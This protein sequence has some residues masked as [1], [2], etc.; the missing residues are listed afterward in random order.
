MKLLLLALIGLVAL[1]AASP[2][3]TTAITVPKYKNNGIH[4]Y[5]C[6]SNTNVLS[7][8]SSGTCS[9]V[10]HCSTKCFADHQGAGCIGSSTVAIEASEKR[11]TETEVNAEAKKT[12][13]CSNDHTGVLVCQYGFCQT[14]RYCKKGTKCHDKCSCCRNMDV[15]ERDIGDVDTTK[16]SLQSEDIFISLPSITSSPIVPATTYGSC[17]QTQAGVQSCR[18]NNSM[19]VVCDIADYMW[20]VLWIA[21]PESDDDFHALPVTTSD[22]LVSR[23]NCVPGTYSCAQNSPWIV[24]CDYKGTYQYSSDCGETDCITDNVVAH[25]WNPGEEWKTYANLASR[26][27]HPPQDG[28]CVPGT[29][30]CVLNPSTNTPWVT[31]CGWNQK[32]QYSSDCGDQNCLARED[33]AAHC[34]NKGD[35]WNANPASVSRRDEPERVLPDLTLSGN[36]SPGSYAC[37]WRNGTQTSWV[38][39]CDQSGNWVWSSDCGR[40]MECDYA[41]GDAHCVPPKSTIGAREELSEVPADLAPTASCRPGEFGC[42]WSK[43]TV[44]DWTIVCDQSGKH[45]LWSSDC[46]QGMKCEWGGGV[47]HCV[48]NKVLFEA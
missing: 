33:G 4:S 43:D 22:T 12:Y 45:W 37:G 28:P 44:T 13:E 21:Q 9:F 40:G 14:D 6:D 46:G 5:K 3:E 2:V 10:E 17:K 42:A 41:N 30:G 39:T 15:L 38:I 18:E 25:C 34:W 24:V 48:L 31:V 23:G 27:D 47:A 1:V 16:V 19:I 29:Y 7:C 32:L 36:C 8:V 26:V 11:D 35:Q 20:R